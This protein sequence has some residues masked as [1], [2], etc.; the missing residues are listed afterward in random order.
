MDGQLSSG[1]VGA[2]A[3]RVTARLL[4]AL[5]ILSTVATLLLNVDSLI[6]MA[7][8][9]WLSG[10]ISTLLF[11]GVMGT[12]CRLKY[13]NILGWSGL[14]FFLFVGILSSSPS[15]DVVH[16]WARE[17]FSYPF[18]GNSCLIYI[19]IIFVVIIGFLWAIYY[20]RLNRVY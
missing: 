1:K 16:T 15:E 4:P 8:P 2:M 18:S 5:I 11:L 13:A 17:G 3:D 7:L 10:S 6:P 14:V 19:R 20:R 9:F 12:I